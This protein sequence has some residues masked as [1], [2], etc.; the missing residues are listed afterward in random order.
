MRPFLLFTF[1]LSACASPM[2]AP[3]AAVRTNA[4]DAESLSLSR[5][6]LSDPGQPGSRAAC[7][8]GPRELECETKLVASRRARTPPAER[9]R[10]PEGLAIT[11]EDGSV[12]YAQA[13]RTGVSQARLRSSL[14]VTARR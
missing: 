8:I 13:L 7:P 3:V 6:E 11:S 12:L 1:A 4:P 2:S 14:P 10:E 9:A 5:F